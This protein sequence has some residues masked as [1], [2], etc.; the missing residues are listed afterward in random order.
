MAVELMS[1]ITILS[2]SCSIFFGYKA[3]SRNKEQDDKMD[4][5]QIATVIVKLDNIENTV[6]EIKQ[7]NKSF[8]VDIQELRERFI[9][10]ESRMSNLEDI[11]YQDTPHNK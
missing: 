1:V 9:K 4:A 2:V 10:L 11:V 8:K 7:D 5:T 3:F 6:N